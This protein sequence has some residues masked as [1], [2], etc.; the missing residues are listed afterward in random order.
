HGRCRVRAS[1][2]RSSNRWCSSTAD[3]CASKTPT[4]AASPLERRFT[5]CS[6]AVGCRF[7][8]FPVRRL[9]LGARTSRTLGVRRTLSQWNLSPRAQ[10]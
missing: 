5:C 8:S 1:G 7:R 3:C 9:A 2:W 10:P 6:P 4:Q